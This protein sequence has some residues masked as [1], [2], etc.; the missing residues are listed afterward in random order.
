MKPVHEYRSVE[1]ADRRLQRD[2]HA[3]IREVEAVC[4]E[5]PP[6]VK[7]FAVA[8]L[9]ALRASVA[10]REAPTTPTVPAGKV[11]AFRAR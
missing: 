1:R 7:Y 6:N 11:V 2:I 4:G 8:Q 9:G 5:R 10:A 3:A